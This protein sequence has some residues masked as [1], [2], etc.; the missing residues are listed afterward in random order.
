MNTWKI[1]M[2]GKLESTTDK[3][4]KIP[5]HSNC[6]FKWI[7]SE[8]HNIDFWVKLDRGYYQLE[9][10]W[11]QH[12]L[13]KSEYVTLRNDIGILSKAKQKVLMFPGATYK[14]M[15]DCCM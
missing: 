14:Q 5:P 9:D 8:G 11:K 12:L 7:C 1:P 4:S 3:W 15:N 13:V 2:I 6:M 10:Q